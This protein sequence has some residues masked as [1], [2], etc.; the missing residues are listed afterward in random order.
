MTEAPERLA[1][2]AET[3]G[4]GGDLLW[5]KD[6]IIYQL[7]VKAFFDADND[8]I[9]DFKGLTQ[10]LDYIKD[11]GVTAIW[12]M[13][14]YPS[15]MRDDGYDISEYKNVHP[16]YGTMRDVRAFVR[17]AHQLGLKVIT[18]LVI[19][20]TSD[21]HPWF[22]RARR[23]PKGSARRNFY[24]WSDTT[25]RYEGTPIIFTD[26]ENSN[27]AWDEVA[28]QYFWH[29][30]FSH[31][32]DLNHD[33]PQVF[34]AIMR[35]MR[36]WLDAG[37]D[38]LRLDA[39]PYLIEREGTDNESLPETH[40]ILKQM[41]A[42]MDARYANR[43][44]LAEANQWPEDLLPYFADGDECH[45]AFHFPLMPRIFMAVA[46]EDRHPIVEI[47]HQTPEIPENCQ[48]AIFL[49][50]H[51]EL[52][53]EMV[54]DRE[55]DYMYQAY[56]TDPR[57][58]VNLGIRRRLAPMMEND[59]PRIELLNSLLMSMPGTPIVY[60]GD[61]IGMGD[62]IFL[63]DRDSVRTPMQW[64]SD[65]NAGFSRA[66]P[67][68][69]YLPPIMDPVYGYEAV[70]VE[71]QG[72]SA[73]S[74]LSW[75]KRLISVRKANRA[76]GRGTLEFL[77]PGNRKILAYLREYEDES[78]LCVANLSRSAQPVEL[79]LTRFQGRV[80]VELLG[81]TSFP[82]LSNVPYLLTLPGHSFYWFRLALSS[83][84]AAPSWHEESPRFPEPPVIVLPAGRET[85]SDA[86][87]APIRLPSRQAAQLGEALPGFLG[88]R[89]WFA[90]KREEIE[91]V[92]VAVQAAL[93]D[94]SL[95][96]LLRVHVATDGPEPQLYFLPLSA[97]WE[98]GGDADISALVP[99]AP[100]KLRRRSRMGV[101]YDALADEDFCREV[102]AAMGENREVSL[103]GGSVRFSRTGVYD[104]LTRD[105]RGGATGVRRVGVEQSN[106][107]V[108]IDERLIL[109]AYRRL[110]RGTN[111]DLEIGRYLTEEVHF[112]NTPPVAGAIEYE[113][114]GAEPVTLALLQGF[115]ANQGDGYSYTVD[116]LGRYLEHHLLT[117]WSPEEQEGADAQRGEPEGMETFF[118]GLMHTLGLRTGELHAALAAP[119]DDEAF[120]PDP[121]AREEVAGWVESVVA[122]VGSTF[123]LL[124][125]RRGGLPEEV[126][127]GLDRLLASRETVAGRIGTI[128]DVG[129]AAVKTRYHGEYHLGQVLVVNN[130]FEI[131]DFEGEPGRP[132]SERRA[133]HSPLRDVAGMLRSFDYAAQAALSNLGAERAD[134][135]RSLEPR[136]ERWKR[137][138]R[139][140]F[141]DAYG[142]GARGCASHPQNPY[143]FAKLVELFTFEKALFE[144]R[145]EL[146]NRPTL[147]GI[148][149]RAI[150]ALIEQ[151][152]SETTV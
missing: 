35:V 30:F 124:E 8:G 54:T 125:Q 32:P 26:T 14:F 69:L 63:G 17:K 84:V 81:G 112:E 21:Q 72:R 83:E 140:A 82:P 73:G 56:A 97:A 87:R 75:M 131:I 70:N 147:V 38:G 151:P 116:Y 142:E 88:A 44:F 98:D 37:V 57:M 128:A 10:R 129:F 132:L 2:G 55:R 7:H 109:K 13:P 49:R 20:H 111:P 91:R 58:R 119:T 104:D 77:H 39:V 52:T 43:L 78:I 146:D 46:Q 137:R 134:R 107:S 74:L 60:Y 41:R 144:I 133:K 113:E 115:V 102:V 148:P 120:S 103:R 105:E 79:D 141:L 127:P 71:A 50:N 93:D 130:D 31:Q 149:I 19:N 96:T 150:L 76:F 117:S 94:S 118:V 36:F 12:V 121:A 143:H 100:A 110:Q 138:A 145:Y 27:W 9:G 29:R 22:Q 90:A 33:N 61:E 24:V 92:E 95:L 85:T 51:D 15:P 53:L 59:R 123:E 25:R 4:S 28:G 42:E 135:L 80:P 126:R 108:I 89:R 18:E 68:R 62:N 65:R 99:H 114:P 1:G 86:Y 152:A 66:E 47:M 11:L 101:L 40:E 122:E 6:A 48:W 3:E 16:E 45:M 106:S 139:E 67:A 64:T 136:V 5:Y 23:A 34:K